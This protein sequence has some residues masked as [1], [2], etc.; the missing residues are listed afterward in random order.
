MSTRNIEKVTIENAQIRWRNLS[1]KEG[2]FN[3][4]GD[5]NFCVFLDPE[6]ATTL[7]E[8]GWSVKQAKPREDGD[9]PQ[10][11]IQ[12]TVKYTTNSRPPRIV[13]ITKRG[14]TSLTEQEINILDWAEI[15][16][17]DL[18]FRPYNWDV[19]GK[20]GVKAYLESLFVTVK[21]DELELKYADIPDTAQ[22]YVDTPTEEPAF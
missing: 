5:R 2:R 4:P 21:E 8:E 10:D 14:R 16:T 1:G 9:P 19:N 17:A 11:Y 3:K 6:M 18:I 7:I 15:E 12:I 13:M 20:Q 22:G